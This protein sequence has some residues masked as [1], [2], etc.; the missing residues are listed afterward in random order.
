VDAL[1]AG[2]GGA[3]EHL[4][5]LEQ[6]GF[7]DAHR[8]GD[9]VLHAAHVGEAQ[10]HELDGVV[11]DEFLDVRVRHGGRLRRWRGLPRQVQ[12][13]CHAWPY[14]NALILLV[15]REMR[16]TGCTLTVQP[17]I[18]IAPMWCKWARRD[19]A[20]PHPARASAECPPQQGADAVLLGLAQRH[21][22]EAGGP[23]RAFVEPGLVGEAEGAVAAPE[24]R[25]GLEE[26]QHLAVEGPGRHAVP[27]P[28]R[29][30]RA[31]APISLLVVLPAMADSSLCLASVDG[32]PAARQRNSAAIC[33]ESS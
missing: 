26:A 3:V 15:L 16:H 33:G 10:V 25:G 31:A 13:A 12:G 17:P 22:P 2:D 19:A 6:R 28:G 8:E 7:D 21:Q 23:H 30:Y 4:A 14:R 9:V 29:Q 18:N 1:P 11:L 27:G 20:G 5:V 32:C 24:L